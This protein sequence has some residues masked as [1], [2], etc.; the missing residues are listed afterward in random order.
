MDAIRTGNYNGVLNDVLEGHLD[1]DD[2][3]GKVEVK[4]KDEILQFLLD[5]QQY[6]TKSNGLG[7]FIV[8]ISCAR[9]GSVWP[10]LLLL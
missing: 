5:K 2:L 10:W 7:Q 9:T 6:L 3:W 4:G 8:F 1:S